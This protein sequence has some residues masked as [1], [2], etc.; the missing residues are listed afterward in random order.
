MGRRPTSKPEVPTQKQP[1]ILTIALSEG[2]VNDLFV[3]LLTNR[4]NPTREN[5]RIGPVRTAVADLA[6][7]RS[8][9]ARTAARGSGTP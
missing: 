9:S 8:Q 4:V 1:G 2:P 3:I 6:E 5:S 7:T